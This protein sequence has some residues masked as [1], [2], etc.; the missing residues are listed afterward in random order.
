MDTLS[1]EEQEQ[2]EEQEEEKTTYSYAYSDF[3]NFLNPLRKTYMKSTNE[4]KANNK[5]A[6]NFLKSLLK[7]YERE[8]IESV[9]LWKFKKES[10]NA[11]NH[12]WLVPT[13]MLRPSNFTRSYEMMLNDKPKSNEPSEQWN[14]YLKRNVEDHMEINLEDVKINW[15]SQQERT[16]FKMWLFNY[17]PGQDKTHLISKLREKF[18][19]QRELIE[20]E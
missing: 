16:D 20:N 6:S 18:A 7:T 15:E 14:K 1:Q 9:I 2:E 8:D 3:I 4:L 19:Q 13:T 10:A 11:D 17:I 5:E 12:K